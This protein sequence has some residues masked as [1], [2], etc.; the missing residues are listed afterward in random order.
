MASRTVGAWQ[1][2]QQIGVGSFA[3]VWRAVY[4]S[5][6][7]L[8][9]IKEIHTDK[10]N[11]KLH[12]SLASEISVLQ[13]T[14]H[15]NIVGL[16]ELLQEPGRIFLVLEYCGGGDLSHYL[17]RYGRVP[18]GQARHLLLQLVE[19][20]KVLRS[21][22][23]IHRDLKPQNLLLTDGS[24][25][26]GLK[27]ADFGFAR[28]LQ[29]QGLAE[30]LCG[31]PLYMAPEILQFH[32][33]DAKADLWSVGVILFE[34]LAG[35]PPY[36]GIN[37]LQLLK[38]IERGEGGRLPDAIAD[39]LSPAC[40]QLL[41]QLLRRNPVERIGYEEFFDHPFLR[42]DPSLL[43]PT[44]QLPPPTPHDPADPPSPSSH[45]PPAPPV[46]LT[47]PTSGLTLPPS[48]PPPLPPHPAL[49]SGSSAAPQP[50][51]PPPSSSSSSS[52]GTPPHPHPRGAPPTPP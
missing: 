11:S 15:K 26:P 51:P 28:D 39:A 16:V 27:I 9:A 8:V 20:L 43:P 41:H 50:T 32:K 37:H 46:P 1:L 10:L 38:N 7:A 2:E 45:H 25:Q 52:R 22:N 44:H 31:S 48:P 47:G 14:A 33:Y 21:H 40:K 24:R 36:N 12:A 18:E 42:T 49:P 19:G 35:K 6:G 3:T 29:P 13:R 30:T 34:L 5:T 17:R 4:Q 23:L